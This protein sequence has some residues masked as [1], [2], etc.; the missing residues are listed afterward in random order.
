MKGFGGPFLLILHSFYRPKV[1]LPFQKVQI[2]TILQCAVV[3]ATG[4]ALSKLG[5]F[6]IFLPISLHNLLCATSDEFRS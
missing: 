3:I 4:E 2:N 6:P 1:F 5:V